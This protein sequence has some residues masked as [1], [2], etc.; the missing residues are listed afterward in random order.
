MLP[1]LVTLYIYSLTFQ[2]V[3]SDIKIL[4]LHNLI[5]F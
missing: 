3:I 5:I 4:F 1:F 2:K